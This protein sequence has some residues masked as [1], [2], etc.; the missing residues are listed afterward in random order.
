MNALEAFN[1]FVSTGSA[2]SSKKAGNRV[3]ES[4][5]IKNSRVV[6]S[7]RISFSPYCEYDIEYISNSIEN[8]VLRFLKNVK[9]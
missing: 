3:L 4:M 7:I 2:C 6:G 9:K 8:C 5:G 1:I